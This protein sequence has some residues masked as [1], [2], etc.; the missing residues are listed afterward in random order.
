MNWESIFEMSYQKCYGLP[1]DQLVHFLT[2][3]HMP[4]SKEEIAEISGNQRN[5]FPVSDPLHKLYQPFDPAKWSIPNKPLPVDYLDFLRYSNG[6]EFG[7]GK[8][9]FQF[10]G[11]DELR[12]LLLAYEFPEYMPG[13]VPFATDGC[14][15]HYIWDMRADRVNHEYPILVSHSGNLGYEDAALIAGT[16]MELCRGTVSAEAVL[17]G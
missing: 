10:F 7:N 8:R 12:A 17:H 4:L 2:Q 5:P 6:G 15:N 14:G 3:W 13:A 16:F 11:A 1:E 9:H